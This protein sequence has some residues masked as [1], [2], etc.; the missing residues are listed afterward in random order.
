M[1]YEERLLQYDAVTLKR[2]E[3]IQALQI[4]TEKQLKL[5]EEI[6]LLLDHFMSLNQQAAVPPPP[7]P[8][9]PFY[10]PAPGPSSSH[11]ANGSNG[12]G[13]ANGHQD[14]RQRRA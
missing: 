6:D 1:T 2:A 7:Q 10:P 3:Y 4:A 11:H 5:Q 13:D 8:S 14:K 9:R 12:N